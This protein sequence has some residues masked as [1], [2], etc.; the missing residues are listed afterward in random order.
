MDDLSRVHFRAVYLEIT[1]RF[2]SPE[3]AVELKAAIDERVFAE[4][5]LRK[6]AAQCW[7]QK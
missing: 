5:G 7:E 4:P 6:A 2:F 1:G 3:E